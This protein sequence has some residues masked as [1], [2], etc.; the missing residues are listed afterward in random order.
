[1]NGAFLGWAMNAWFFYRGS[2]A[3]RHGSLSQDQWQP[4]L[5]VT[6]HHDLGIRTLGKVF[7][8]FDAFPLQQ[9]R[10]D[11]LGDNLLKV[12][13]TGGFNPLALRFLLFFLQSEVHG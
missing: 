4:I 10:A 13:D 6:N 7:C 1:M 11:A 2:L 9:L 12:T 3:I 5:I 8:G